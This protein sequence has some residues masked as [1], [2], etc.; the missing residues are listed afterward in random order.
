MATPHET[1]TID[2]REVKISNPDKVYFPAIGQTKLDIARYFVAVAEGALRGCYNRPMVLKRWV[3][4]IDGEPFYQKRAPQNRPAWLK[5]VMITFPSGRTAEEAV[6]CHAADLVWMAN[7]GCIDLN[8]WPVRSDDVDRPDEL[9]VDL[10]PTPEAD[11]A[12]VR[13]VALAVREVLT[14]NGLTGFPKTSGSRGIHINVRIERSW[15]F[16]DVRMAALALAREVERRWPR[17]ATSKWWKEE[18]HGVFIDYNQNARDRTV[19]SAYSIRAMPDGRVSCPIMWEEVGEVNPADFTMLTVPSR[20]AERGDAAKGID[21]AVGSLEGLL[22][23]SKRQ[24]SEGQEDA[25]YPPHFPKAEGEPRRVQ[26]SRKK[27]S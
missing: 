12:M 21:E 26:P 10:D 6:I 27:K 18:R 25:P 8:P 9:R 1:L 4:G 5:T 20:F 19:A 15:G 16:T 24:A 2:G 17:I 13:E 7:L 23:L 22:E 14:E 3:D 11:F